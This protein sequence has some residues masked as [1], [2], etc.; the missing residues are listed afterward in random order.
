[1]TPDRRTVI[2]AGLAAAATPALARTAD[3]LDDT[4]LVP[5]RELMV[6]VP[7]G[8][9]Y[10]R[11]NGTSS[12]SRLPLVLLHGGPGSTHAGIINA[13]AL[14]ADRMVIL[15]DQLDCGRSDAPGSPENWQIPRFLDELEAIRLALGIARWHVMGGSW[16][17]TLALEYGARQPAAL[18]GLV[19]QSPLVSTEVWLRD[20]AVL[21]AAMPAETAR[22]LDLCDTPGAAPEEACK[23]A[24]DAFYARHVRRHEP[25]P[26]L[27]AYAATVRT[28][29]DRIIYEA[30]WG[31][32]EFTATGS[33]KNYD[34]RP[35]LA[36]LDGTRTLFLAGEHDEARPA[37]VN[38]FAAALPGGA[39]FQ[40]VPD[41]AHALWSD[42]PYAL[43]ALLRPWLARIERSI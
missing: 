20:A 11:T 1:M 19:L 6:D 4:S 35:L 14:A 36:R 21:K 5:D 38:E 18:A 33:L 27:S 30:M 39:A 13:T 28:P 29:N 8:R 17:G 43:A 3:M 10:V 24:T 26:A 41:A 25:A 37:T 2:G 31:R 12:A 32:A 16:G 34:G 40:Q 15:Y 9:V 42:N 22:L 7:G 23:A